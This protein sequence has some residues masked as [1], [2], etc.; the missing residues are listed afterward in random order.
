M[1]PDFRRIENGWLQDFED[2]R[3]TL[4]LDR[5]DIY[6]VLLVMAIVAG[7]ILVSVR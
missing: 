3:W 6:F 5:G 4:D 1:K 2:G 7:F